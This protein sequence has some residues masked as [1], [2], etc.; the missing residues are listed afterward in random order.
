MAGRDREGSD[1]GDSLNYYDLLGVER[2]ASPEEV[3]KV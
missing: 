3:K 1:S 2:D